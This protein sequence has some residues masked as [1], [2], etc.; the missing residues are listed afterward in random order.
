M[1]CVRVCFPLSLVLCVMNVVSGGS[2][3]FRASSGFKFHLP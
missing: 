1:L 3:T 2:E